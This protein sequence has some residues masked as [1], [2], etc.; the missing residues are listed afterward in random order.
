MPAAT[1]IT[2]SSST[3]GTTIITTVH[4]CTDDD[5]EHTDVNTETVQLNIDYMFM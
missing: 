2:T 1:T 3:Q 4:D 5:C